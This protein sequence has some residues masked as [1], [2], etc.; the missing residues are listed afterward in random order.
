MNRSVWWTFFGCLVA[1]A[2]FVA[3]SPA[4]A[5]VQCV[6]TLYHINS[7]EF[8]TPPE[9]STHAWYMY[10][11]VGSGIDAFAYHVLIT[12]GSVANGSECASPFVL[13]P[14]ADY[15]FIRGRMQSED[16]VKETTFNEAVTA[17]SAKMLAMSDHALILAM[18]AAALIGLFVGYRF[19][20]RLGDV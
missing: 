16:I 3:S 18:V 10:G 6:S 4:R 2:L 20:V 11:V 12:G 14:A 17:I 8:A 15:N 13:I 5:G 19:M 9:G 1:M 7:W